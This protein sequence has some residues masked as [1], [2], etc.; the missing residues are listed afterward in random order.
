MAK[1]EKG[2]KIR[3]LA[4][5]DHPLFREGIAAVLRS[6]PDML[7]VAEAAS[8]GEAIRLFREQRP[9][10]ILMDLELPDL[11]GIDA[12]VAIRTEFSGARIVILSAFEH[13]VEVQR[14]LHSGARAYLSK[15]MPSQELIGVIRQVHAGRK[16]VPSA[17]AVRLAEHLGDENLTAREVQVLEFVAGGLQNRNI[18]QRLFIAEGTVKRHMKNI[19]QKLGAH[20]RTQAATI[21]A[22]RGIIRF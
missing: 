13:E 10:V 2:T 15:S 11:S 16:I 7:L 17:L 14:A 18:G 21:A 22:R 5:D 19:M 20:D 8:G 12:M 9:D 3:I 4:V 1:I 6:Q